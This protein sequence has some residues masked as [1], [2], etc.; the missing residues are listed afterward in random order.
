M[1]RQELLR[2][3]EWHIDLPK[4]E[5]NKQGY[6][7]ND[8]RCNDRRRVPWIAARLRQNKTFLWKK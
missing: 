2:V 5:N 7:A 4:R 1:Q 8:Q 6:A 3:L